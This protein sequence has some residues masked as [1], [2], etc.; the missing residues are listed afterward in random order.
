LLEIV[1]KDSS[2]TFSVRV[3]PRSSRTEIVG[4]RDGALKVKLK[5]PPVEGAAN[6][7]LVRFLSKLFGVTQAQL[8][9]VSGQ[10]SRNKRI[11]ISDLSADKISSILQAKI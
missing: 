7:E 10:T 5:S 9:I 11:R 6:E 3:I 4:E 1:E 2:V 8:E